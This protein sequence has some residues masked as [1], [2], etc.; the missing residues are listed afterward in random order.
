VG[1]TALA[2]TANLEF[3]G[4]QYRVQVAV[5]H[6]LRE[7]I[8]KSKLVAPLH[9]A[10]LKDADRLKHH[11]LGRFKQMID[12]ARRAY[13]EEDPIRR[14]ALS[15]RISI[16]LNEKVV[17]LEHDLTLADGDILPAG[18]MVE[19]NDELEYARE[20]AESIE[21]LDGF[22]EAQRFIEYATGSQTPLFEHL[23][24]SASDKGLVATSAEDLKRVTGWLAAWL[25]SEGKVETIQAVSR[26]DAGLFIRNVLEQGRSR[27]KANAY[28][29]FLKN[30]WAWLSQKGHI[31]CENP[32]VGQEIG[33]GGVGR[34]QA[35][36]ATPK[37][38]FT[39]EE[40]VRL[41]SAPAPSDLG[42]AMRIAALSGMRIEEI[43]QLRLS[44][45]TNGL[46][47]IRF[48]KTDNAVRIFPIHSMLVP[49]VNE[50]LEDGEASDFLIK[51]LRERTA[52]NDSRSDPLGKAFMR[53]RRKLG[54][55]SAKGSNR[56]RS[57]V[58]FH[59]F[60]RWFIRVVRDAINDRA[61]GFSFHTLQ[62]V[63]GH[64]TVAISRSEQQT[65]D[66]SG[67]SPM[68]AKQAVI[69]VVRLPEGIPP[70]ASIINQGS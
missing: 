64:S 37:R 21:R 34:K 35:E 29:S 26:K 51:G 38:P 46:F 16:L 30:Y 14:E 47:N 6:K 58:E 17:P 57:E 2:K 31:E 52:S 5:P 15:L 45:C 27:N 8:G 69:E 11:H 36:K 20:R 66:Y 39:D 25:K 55:G 13:K 1:I 68:S 7:I 4:Q 48:G 18:T 24:A 28:L 59:S 22:A 23:E 49:F 33:F 61:L 12:D 41:L 9:T 44:D 67:Q 60:R 62:E 43:C 63:V 65:Q 10:S 3:H 50:R 19:R 40:I 53:F 56:E 42:F 54:I 32:W 70:L